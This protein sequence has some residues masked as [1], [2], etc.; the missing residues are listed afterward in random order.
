MSKR[1]TRVLIADDHAA[2]CQALTQFLAAEGDTD[3][4]GGA[5][6]GVEAV[7]LARKLRPDVVVMD[8]N[9]PR[10]NGI[11][12]TRQ[13][14]ARFPSMKIIGFCLGSSVWAAAMRTAGAFDC[15]DKGSGLQGLVAAIRAAETRP[16]SA[17][18]HY[19]PSARHQKLG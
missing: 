17:A 10:L 6:D 13:L 11:E 5:R 4:I 18:R 8:V 19:P 16:A 1:K 2:V 12:A 7:A 14:A 3:V 15:V 9:M